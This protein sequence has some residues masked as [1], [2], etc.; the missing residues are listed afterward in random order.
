MFGSDQQL[1]LWNICACMVFINWFNNWIH[2]WGHEND[3][4]LLEPAI[5]LFT[6]RAAV[7][8]ETGCQIKWPTWRR[9]GGTASRRSSSVRYACM[10]SWSPCSC[11]ANTTSAGAA[12]ARPGRRTRA[13]CAVRSATTRTT[14]NQTWRKTLSWTTSWKS[15]TRWTSTKRRRCCTA[16]CV[17]EDLPFQRRECVCVVTR[18]VASRTFRHIS[19]SP[20]RLLATYWW[21]PRRSGPGAVR[22][23]MNT[24]S[25]IA[26]WNR[27]LSA[28]IAAS[29][30]VHLT[31]ATQFATWKYD[32]M[33]SGWV[34]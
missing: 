7:R 31:T 10:C 22:I 21:R 14:R 18:R 25:I 2:E 11:P 19:N 9:A 1:F 8:L 20:V 3:R 24:D 33:I 17:G 29:P 15:S 4:T 28:S 32:A 16:F 12:S 23:M 5:C 34:F 6:R 26:M 27:W 30:D 13:T